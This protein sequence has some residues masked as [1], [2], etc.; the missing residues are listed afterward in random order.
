MPP[1]IFI[2]QYQYQET[3]VKTVGIIYNPEKERARKELSNLKRWLTKK[4]CKAITLSSSETELPPLDFAITL[5]GDGTMLKAS[6]ALAPR[7]IP[8][9]GVNL[10]SL[11]FLAETDPGEVYRFL[12]A[13]LV[14]GFQIE[15][16][17]MLSVALHIGDEVINELALNE[18][19]LR[20][21]SSGRVLAVN[22]HMDNEL[23]AD[24][25]GDGV[26]VA[27]PT[28]S[29]AYSLAASGPIVH[30]RLS[31]F[32]LTPIC[33]HTLAQRPLIISPKH[34]LTLCIASQLDHEKPLVS[35]DGQVTYTMGT[36]DTAVITT[37]DTPL[38]LIINP[39]RKYLEVLRTKLKWGG[40]G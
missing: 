27:T 14:K 40:R 29:T 5:G 8:V 39:D 18:V 32:I 30:P 11:G 26:I 23:L 21:G 12:S 24:Y 38:R 37:S 1:V 25:V 33:P 34:T 22:A 6:R 4:K 28:G 2:C 19:I 13:A 10:G 36:G 31:V 17:M 20:S 16:R 35:L 7:K 9:L 3:R 15:E